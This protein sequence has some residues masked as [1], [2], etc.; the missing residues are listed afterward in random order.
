MKYSDKN[1]PMQCFMNQSN[2]MKGA[3][4]DGTPVGILWHD[5]AAGNSYIERYVQPDD[6]APNR[7]ELLEILGVNPNANDWNHS[8]RDGGV[9]AFIGRLA[10]DSV[11]TVQVGPWTTHAWGCGGDKK[12]SCNGYVRDS[13]G[14]TTWVKP[15]WIQFEICDDSKPDK[16]YPDT[17]RDYTLG[18]PKYFD[19]IYK[20]ACELTAYLCKKFNIDPLG[21]ITFN[22]VK[23]PTITCH[24]ESY[25]YQLGSDHSDVLQWFKVYSYTMDR[26]R[27]DV[28]DLL[29]PEPQ[30][31]SPIKVGDLVSVQPGATW[32]SGKKVPDWVIEDKWYVSNIDGKRAVIDENEA[33]NNSIDSPI[34]IDYLILEKAAT[35]TQIPTS[36]PTTYNLYRIGQTVEEIKAQKASY[37]DFEKAKAICD[38]KGYSYH[39]FTVN[40]EL[41]YS[42][43]APEIE[44]PVDTEPDTSVTT[45]E[46]QL[47]PITSPGDDIPPISGEPVVEPTEPSTTPVITNPSSTNE[48]S[49]DDINWFIK[50][51][52]A[53]IA[54][55]RRLFGNKIDE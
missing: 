14:N 12:G 21:T 44:T 23:M 43:P 5:T 46:P 33:H 11:T 8:N 52:K 38:E 9:N 6:D 53:F 51:I 4:P 50:M 54:A 45:E 34:S 55:L 27:H 22:G 3:I 17:K 28:A 49:E 25:Q 20:E 10:N 36:K 18:D 1:P 30:P 2:W 32:W 13:K 31:V 35:S 37:I 41:V 24:Q 26:V 48:P 29:K 7:A 19:T 15:F 16:K 40:G 39:V 42:A 47:D